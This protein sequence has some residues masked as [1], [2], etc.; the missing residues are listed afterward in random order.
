MTITFTLLGTGSPRPS[1]QRSQPANLVH[2]AAGPLLI[3]A[4]EGTLRQLL[5]LDVN[6]REVRM[7]LFTHMHKDHILGYP[8][9]VWAGW[10]L[11]RP[12]LQVTGPPGTRRMHELLFG[13]LYAA[14]IEYS[15]GIGFES[16]ALAGVQVH[17]IES[18]AEFETHGFQVRTT[19]TIHSFYNLAYRLDDG[20]TSVVFTGDTTY[21]EDVVTL[22]QGAD[23]MVCEVTLA[24]SPE[25]D[26]DRGR[27]IL[28]LLEKDHCN[29]A[30][31]GRMAKEAGVGR[32]IVNH[33]IPGV[34]TDLIREGC[35]EEFAGPI[36]IGEDL[37]TFSV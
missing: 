22:A 33:L 13:E 31:A 16:D 3:D 34:R 15:K 37:M 28:H 26:N 17:E 1:P 24:Q 11:G 7:M 29:P 27:R 10:T 4:G 14:D 35:A 23:A 18:G 36:T 20:K 5:R 32:L 8:A 25:Y 21:C 19:R 6:P 12:N 30:M 9:V 2:T